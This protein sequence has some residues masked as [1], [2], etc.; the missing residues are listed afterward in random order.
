MSSIVPIPPKQDLPTELRGIVTTLSDEA[1][2][3]ALHKCQELGFDVNRGRIPL[4]ETFINLSQARDILL[5]A[6]DKGKLVQM[7]LTL[8][9]ALHEQAQKV[10]QSLTALVNGTD[11]VL[12]LDDAVE[13]LAASIWQ[14]NLHNLSDQV[15]GFHNKMNQLKNLETRIRQ[16]SRRAEE[17]ESLHTTARQLLDQISETAN[18]ASTQWTALQ[19]STEEAD[20]VLKKLTEQEQKTSSLAAQIQQHEITAGQQLA[21]SKQAAADTEAIASKSKELQNEIDANRSA[22]T[23]LTS[24]TQQ[25]LASTENS[26]S[27]QMS[28]FSSRYEQ[29]SSS[30][31]SNVSALTTKLDFSVADLTTT[32]NTKAE[33]ATTALQHAGAELE[34]RVSQLITDSSSLLTQ[35]EATH[36]SKL[37]AK[38]KDFEVKGGAHLSDFSDK[39]NDLMKSVSD[40]AE[41]NIQTGDAEVKRLVSELGELEG[42]IRKSIERATGYTLFESFQKRQLDI[43]KARRFWGYVLGFLVL[44]SLS[45]SGWF[46]SR[47]GDGVRYNAV[48]YLKL[49]LSIPL[50]YAIAFCHAQYS[51]ERR[52]EE[53]YAF[54]SNIS[55]SLEPYQKLV[56]GLVDK[57]QPEELSKFTAFIIDSVNRV[58]TSPTERIFADHS[59]DKT[60]VD[61]LIDKIIKNINDT[62][63][64]LVK[65][66]KK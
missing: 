28:E 16:V 52:L 26:I 20:R 44:V 18:T 58:F 47:L 60:S 6:I 48:F 66:L 25:L 23:D 32:L 56:G 57:N 46:I 8:Q 21:N 7:P 1:Q 15:F 4:E 54:K 9:Y 11:A 39:F 51:R 41:E 65:N 53:E 19:A 22:L 29:L 63:E 55:I 37:G 40:K 45:A 30:T 49:S 43:A 50:V 3:A 38:L 27:S 17:F 2:N 14:F 64:P 59:G 35:S 13:K 36:E 5:D 42:R 33:S 34:T 62:I 24:K 12:N 10:A 31:Q 61:K